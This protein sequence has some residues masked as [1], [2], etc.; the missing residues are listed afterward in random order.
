M[1]ALFK[2]SDKE[3]GGIAWYRLTDIIRATIM[4]DDMEQMYRGLEEVVKILTPSN[5]REFNDRY[6]Q[7]MAGNYRDLQ[8]LSD[9]DEHVCELQLNTKKMMT[10]KNTTGHRDFEVVRELIAAVAEGNQSRVLSALEVRHCY[11]RGTVTLPETNPFTYSSRSLPSS[12]FG[13]I[14]LA[15]KEKGLKSLLQDS[16]LT[17]MHDAARL[18]H[19]DILASFLKNGGEKK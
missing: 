17:V 15:D 12:Q 9:V 8:L 5:I 13:R 11:I 1:K 3:D 10:A 7:P 4:F 2:Y 18:G 16:K 6:V 14:H 19:A